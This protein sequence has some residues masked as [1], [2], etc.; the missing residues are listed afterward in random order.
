MKTTL[1]LPD[2]TLRKAEGTASALE[3]TQKLIDEEF[4]QI[5]PEDR[6]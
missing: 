3:I 4:E 6:I 1:E 2:S 5:E